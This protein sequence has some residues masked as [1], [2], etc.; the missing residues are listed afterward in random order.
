MPELPETHRVGVFL[1]QGG[2]AA[3][4][5]A[6]LAAM[7]GAAFLFILG[8]ML[9]SIFYLLSYGQMPFLGLG[10]ML[11]TFTL[12]MLGTTRMLFQSMLDQQTAERGH[13]RALRENAANLQRFERAREE[14]LAVAGA[15]PG[16]ALFDQADSLLV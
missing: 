5:A 12:A 2:M 4:A 10:L 1:V 11:I 16:F 15:G 3:G 13:E 9:P 8:C 6:T 14:W 7:P